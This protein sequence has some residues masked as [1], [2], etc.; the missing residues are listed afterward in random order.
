MQCGFTTHFI[1]R[2][3]GIGRRDGLKIRWQRCRVGSS[4]TS[5]TKKCLAACDAP[6]R[7]FCFFWGDFPLISPYVPLST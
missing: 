7:R 6:A 5:G 3:D 2:C 1:S 4:P